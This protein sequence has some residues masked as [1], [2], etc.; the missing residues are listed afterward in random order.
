MKK[1][2]VISMLLFLLILSGCSESEYGQTNILPSGNNT[3]QELQELDDSEIENSDDYDKKFRAA[4]TGIS[5]LN[6]NEKTETKTVYTLDNGNVVYSIDKTSVVYTNLH[7]NGFKIGVFWGSDPC[8]TTQK[9]R[10]LVRS[11]YFSVASMS[12]EEQFKAILYM[13][14]DKEKQ[15]APSYEELNANRRLVEKKPS[16]GEI[17]EYNCNSMIFKIEISASNGEHTSRTLVC[18]ILN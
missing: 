12:L 9:K 18:D 17:Y 15:T 2:I 14:T 7:D 10:I 4:Y 6:L 3:T 1:T 5:E 13:M 11:G 16:G 8:I